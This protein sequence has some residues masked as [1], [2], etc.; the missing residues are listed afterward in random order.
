MCE[1]WVVCD[2][3]L[4]RRDDRLTI[5]GPV[6]ALSLSSRQNSDA[7]DAAHWLVRAFTT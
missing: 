6:R 7:D 1:A 2:L 5:L 3:A 4:D